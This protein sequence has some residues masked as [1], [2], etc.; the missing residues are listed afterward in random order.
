MNLKSFMAEHRISTGGTSPSNQHLFRQVALDDNE[1]EIIKGYVR[2]NFKGMSAFNYALAGMALLSIPFGIITGRYDFIALFPVLLLLEIFTVIIPWQGK[3]NLKKE[4]DNGIK[5]IFE[6]RIIQKH[7][8]KYKG[9]LLCF[10]IFD[11]CDF[12]VPEQEYSLYSEGD[13]IRIEFTMITGIIFRISPA[14]P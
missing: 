10:F 3:K 6:G 12:G 1:R 14:S 5:Y 8:S 13:Y 7:H 2:L 9:S 11:E 4:L